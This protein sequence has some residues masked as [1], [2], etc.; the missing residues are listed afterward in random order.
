VALAPGAR[1]SDDLRARIRRAIREQ[2]SPRHV[3]NGILSAPGVPV[4]LTGKK[5]EVL[6]K[7]LLQ[8]VPEEKAVNRAT[9]ANPDVL[10]WYVDFAAHVG[11]RAAASP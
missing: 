1:L 7:R 6:V 8:G 10:A 4:T 2:V 3:P 11:K 9:V 5:L